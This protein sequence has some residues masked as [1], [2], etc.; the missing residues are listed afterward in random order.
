ME[1]N[2][3][4]LDDLVEVY[5]GDLNE[6]CGMVP[7]MDL[8]RKVT[9]GCGPSIYS[10][11]ASTVAGSQKQELATVKKSFLIRKL[12][13]PDS[14]DLDAAIDAAIET[15]GRSNRNKYRAVMYYMLTKHFG[16]EN[17]YG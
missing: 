9:I 14:P 1:I 16:K 13:L 8:L 4:R 17:V 11:D 3:S 2:M 6:K 15:Y 5:A 12:G 10:A 7:D